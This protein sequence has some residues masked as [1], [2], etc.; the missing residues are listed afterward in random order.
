MKTSYVAVVV[1]GGVEDPAGGPCYCGVAPCTEPFPL[2]HDQIGGFSARHSQ[3][4]AATTSA[5]VPVSNVGWTTGA[6]PA[7]WLTGMS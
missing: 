4:S 3:A 1:V 2:S 7:E 6:K 5:W